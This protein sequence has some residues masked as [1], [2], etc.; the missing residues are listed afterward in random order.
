MLF[1]PKFLLSFT[2]TSDC[3]GSGAMKDGWG[4]W[5]GLGKTDE[6]RV[7]GWI[8][9]FYLR[10]CYWL[11]TEPP[12]AVVGKYCSYSLP[13]LCP[14]GVL[15]L[16]GKER[17][18]SN[19]GHHLLLPLSKSQIWWERGVSQREKFYKLS[20]YKSREKCNISVVHISVEVKFE[21]KLAYES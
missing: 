1:R 10:D 2:E 6:Y 18:G 15:D 19:M 20:N 21:V 17:S 14:N 13:F 3:L 12:E 16:Q 5:R 4:K 9:R 11:L 7:Q 8:K